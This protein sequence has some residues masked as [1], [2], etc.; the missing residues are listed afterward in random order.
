MKHHLYDGHHL[1][2]TKQQRT[3]ESS[4]DEQ[5][6]GFGSARWTARRVVGSPGCLAVLAAGAAQ[7]RTVRD[8]ATRATPFLR[9][10]RTAR[11]LGRTV[12]DGTGSS[13]CRT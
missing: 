11:A 8:L 7:G 12:R 4:R 9:A 1:F 13:P 10:V 2:G 5:Y 3:I 6:L